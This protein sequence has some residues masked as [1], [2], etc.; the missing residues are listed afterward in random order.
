VPL[1]VSDAFRGRAAGG[2]YGDV[3]E[4]LDWSVGEVLAA[5]QRLELDDQT[6][7]IFLSDNGPWIDYGNHA[8]SVGPFRNSKG[9]A[10]EGG[11]RVPSSRG[12]PDGCRQVSSAA[13]RWSPS[14][15]PTACASTP[16]A[17]PVLPAAAADRR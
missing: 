3:I 6:L 7:V 5:L 14:I 1:F 11:G 2:L 15:S 9:S 13:C 12:S 4:E 10:F 8:G 16:A 17:P